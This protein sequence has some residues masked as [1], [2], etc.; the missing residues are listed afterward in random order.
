MIMSPLKK[1]KSLVTIIRDTPEI[2]KTIAIE[3][4]V[5]V[6][7]IFSK[8][9]DGG[10]EPVPP[11]KVAY[12]L[13]R[14]GF[15]QRRPPIDNKIIIERSLIA[16]IKILISQGW[17]KFIEVDN[18]FIRHDIIVQLNSIG[19]EECLITFSMK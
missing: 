1:K 5:D 6:P 15:P 12:L 7:A 13:N 10:R 14:M 19:S 17:V 2:E 16:L 8:N 4:Y 9:E 18:A 3:S 11:L